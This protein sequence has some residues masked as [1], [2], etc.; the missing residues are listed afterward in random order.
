M[1]SLVFEHKFMMALV[2]LLERSV[3]SG[4][5]ITT[6]K[7]TGIAI[8]GLMLMFSTV[9]KHTLKTTK[10][11][12]TDSEPPIEEFILHLENLNGVDLLEHCQVHDSN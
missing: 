2:I 10:N 7:A 11:Q 4:C 1:H 5:S 9:Q 12:S 8:E 3:S 6:A